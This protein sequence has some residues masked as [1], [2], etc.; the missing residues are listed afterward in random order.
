MTFCTW[1][2]LQGPAFI[3][4]DIWDLLGCFV[5][6]MTLYH[7]VLSHSLLKERPL[8]TILYGM[9]YLCPQV[10]LWKFGD[11]KKVLLTLVSC[12]SLEGHFSQANQ[13]KVKIVK[14]NTNERIICQMFSTVSYWYLPAFHLTCLYRE[15]HGLTDENMV[16]MVSGHAW[17]R[18]PPVPE[19]V[20][21]TQAWVQGTKM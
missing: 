12:V 15:R 1:Y 21:L 10:V 14:Q 17:I 11:V 6:N 2:S 13:T 9:W 20:H 7:Y 4:N 8:K 18:C 5:I 19:S 3:R 16:L